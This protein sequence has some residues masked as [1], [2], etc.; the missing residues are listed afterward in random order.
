M[1]MREF[2]FD[3]DSLFIRYIYSKNSLLVLLI[4]RAFYLLACCYHVVFDT[5]RE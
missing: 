1:M 3:I 2:E 4:I 5:H